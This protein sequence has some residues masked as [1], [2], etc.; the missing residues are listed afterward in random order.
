[1]SPAQFTIFDFQRRFPT[2]E[3]C[4]EHLFACRWPHG[5][6]CPRCRKKE[7]SLIQTRRVVQ[8]LLCGHQTSLTAGTA[9]H[10]TKTPLRFWMWGAYLVATN[11]PGISALKF[12]AQVGLKRY[13]T[14]FTM[15]HKLRAALV[16]DRAV[17]SRLSGTLEVDETYVG[18]RVPGARGRPRGTKAIVVAAVEVAPGGVKGIYVKR[19][20]LR[21]I[22]A[23]SAHYLT[24]FV[25]ERVEPGSTISTDDWLGY[26]WLRTSG[27]RHRVVPTND[28]KGIHRIFS[29]LKAWI[30][31]T[32]HYVSKKH[33]QAYL[34]EF[35]FRFNRRREPPVAFES[36]LGLT[37]HRA[38]P[39]YTGLYTAGSKTGWKHPNVPRRNQG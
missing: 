13:E 33:L 24:Q 7:H 18:G 12:Q 6:V 30:K 37:M 29:N 3:A 28:L 19:I 25:R 15:L 23:A 39:T 31:G 21:K 32:H 10:R 14:A 1:M 35:T 17:E 9:M 4:W 22:P 36:L 11:T 34:N 27:Y 16:Q 38:A 8:C 2:D 5:F 20:K 26:N